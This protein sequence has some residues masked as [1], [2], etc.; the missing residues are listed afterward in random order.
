MPLGN[1]NLKEMKEQA[2]YAP[3]RTKKKARSS[4]CSSRQVRASSAS[5]NTT[6]RK[7]KQ[8]RRSKREAIGIPIVTDVEA[9][10]KGHTKTR[11]VLARRKDVSFSPDSRMAK[12][13]IRPLRA[14]KCEHITRASI[15]IPHLLKDW[16]NGIRAESGSEHMTDNSISVL[17][18]PSVI[19][20]A[21]SAR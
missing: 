10:V 18:K 11:R 9:P 1:Q 7:K 5:E 21:S 17:R 20:R 3:T 14:A 16:T 13:A 12:D 15:H 4:S 19:L 8:Q 6:D 2:A